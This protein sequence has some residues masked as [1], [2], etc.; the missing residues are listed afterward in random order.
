MQPE[1]SEVGACRT[2]GHAARTANCESMCRKLSAPRVLKAETLMRLACSEKRLRC[3]LWSQL[4]ISLMSLADRNA[5][6]SLTRVIFKR[7]RGEILRMLEKTHG[8]HV[9]FQFQRG[10]SVCRSCLCGAE[11][12]GERE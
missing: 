9:I 4:G 1:A 5:L 10:F 6:G 7:R 8:F 11:V 2:C 3:W 12:A